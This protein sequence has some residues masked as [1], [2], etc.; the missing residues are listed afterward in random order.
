M[1]GGANGGIAGSDMR[2]MSY[3]SDG[4]RVNIGIAGD[5]QMTGKQLGT[6]CSVIETR[7]GR[8]LAIFHQYAHVPEQK[9]SIHSKCQFQAHHNLVG[10]TATA[11]GGLQRIDTADGYQIPLTI[12]AGLPYIRQTYPNNEDM[13]LPQV[14]FTSPTEWNPSIND[15]SRTSEEMVRTV[16]PSIPQDAI[17]NFYDE[18]GD[19]N[20]EYLHLSLIHI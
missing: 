20:Y 10:D 4:R 11:Y 8:I 19:I 18:T 5:H 17:D 16:F 2:V 9:R 14:Q 1:D 15:D 3:N 13:N 7:F 6:F 12:R